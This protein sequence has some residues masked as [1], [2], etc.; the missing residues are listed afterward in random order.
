V[1]AIEARLEVEGAEIVH[2][3]FA[4]LVLHPPYRFRKQEF[5]IPSPPRTAVKRHD[6]H[7]LPL[8]GLFGLSGLFGLFGWNQSTTNQRNKKN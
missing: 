8:N 4:A 6:F 7:G 1:A 2:G 5:G 3:N